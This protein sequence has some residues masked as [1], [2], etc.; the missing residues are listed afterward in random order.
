MHPAVA[1]LDAE[2]G[3]R[4]L[5]D[6]HDGG[7]GAGAPRGAG[8]GGGGLGRRRLRGEGGRQRRLR[9]ATGRGARTGERSGSGSGG[10]Q[11][12][13]SSGRRRPAGESPGSSTRRPRRSTHSLVAQPPGSVRRWCSGMIHAEASPMRCV[14]GGHQPTPGRLRRPSLGRRGRRRRP[15][16]RRPGCGPRSAGR[17]AG[18]RRPGA[19][20]RSGRPRRAASA[21]AERARPRRAVA[22]PGVNGSAKSSGCDHRSVPSVR[23]WTPSCQRGSGSP[24]YHLPW[25]AWSRPPGANASAR[26]PVSSHDRARLS[27]P[28]APTVHSTASMSS[29]D[30]KVGSPPSVRRTSPATRRSSTARPTASMRS[31]WSSVYGNVTRGSS[32]TRVTEL[33]KSKV[34]SHG[35]VAP[36]TGR[37]RRRAGR[38]R[39]RDVPLPREQPGGGVEAHPAGAGQEDLAPGVEVGEVGRGARRAVEGLRCRRRAARGSP[40]RTGRRGPGCAGSARAAS[41]CRGTSPAPCRG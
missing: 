16:A 21:A 5:V 10:V 41:R 22:V 28:S 7:A 1:Q 13:E 12:S 37:G 30:T 24:G 11:V 29:I 33:E 40:T 17:R 38:G 9:R 19:G 14:E 4:G 3:G 31:H 36:V 20:T 32:C 23:Q 34:T 39:Q 26:R 8:G 27:S 15:G 2:R 18:P 6:G 25:P 35:S